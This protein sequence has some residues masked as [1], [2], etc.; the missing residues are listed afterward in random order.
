MAAHAWFLIAVLIAAVAVL[1]PL[2]NGRLKLNPFVR[3]VVSVHTGS[4]RQRS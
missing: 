3:L 2:I 4:W 1:V